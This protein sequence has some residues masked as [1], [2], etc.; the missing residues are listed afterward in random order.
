MQL[1]P[2]LALFACLLSASQA[3]LVPATFRPAAAAAA[4]RLTR[5]CSSASNSPS[6]VEG[7]MLSTSALANRKIQF[8]D[9]EDRC[10][11]SSHGGFALALVWLVW[12]CVTAIGGW[13]GGRGRRPM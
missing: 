3:F 11:E 12:T 8:S 6:K 7:V 1:L 5:V 2:S 10:A 4:T 13:A 9:N